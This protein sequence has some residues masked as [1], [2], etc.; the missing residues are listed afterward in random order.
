MVEE[1]DIYTAANGE[2]VYVSKSGGCVAC[3]GKTS[4]KGVRFTESSGKVTIMAVCDDIE[5]ANVLGLRN[6][7]KLVDI[8]KQLKRWNP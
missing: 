4:N 5:C 7:G 3:A 6:N 8:P 2:E 1:I